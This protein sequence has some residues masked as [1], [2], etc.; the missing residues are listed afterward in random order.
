MSK[1]KIF[2]TITDEAP[3]LATHSFLPIVKAFTAPA[4]IEI[5]TSD[6]SL[7]GRTISNFAAALN[8]DQRIADDLVA[9]GKLATTPEANIIKL[10]NIS[11]S[12]PQLQEVIK[13]LQSLGYKLPN[14]PENPTTDDEKAIRAKYGKLLGSAVNPVL[15]EGNSD[16]R[17]PKAV[18]NYAKKNPHIMGAWSADSKTHVSSMD[19]GDFYGSETS[20]TLQEANTYK[21]EFTAVDGSVKTLKEAAPLLAG[22]IIDSAVLSV[23]ELKKF[24]ATQIADAKSSGVLFSLHLKATMMKVSDPIIFGAVVDVFFAPVF[25]KYAA[26]FSELKINTN[27]GFGD[28]LAKIQGRPEQAEVEAAIDA[29]YQMRPSV[30]MVNSDKGITNLNV[31]SD[32]IVDASMPAMIRTSGQMYNADGKGQDTK[33]VIPDRSYAGLYVATIDY[34]KK[35]GAFDPKTMGSVPNVGLMAQAAEEYGSHD[36]TFQITGEG[37]VKVIGSK[38]ETLLEQKVKTGDIFRMCQAKDAPIR[39]WVKLA[40]NRARLSDTPAVFWLDDQRAHDRELI[41]KVTV[42]L[43]DNDTNGLD[44]RILNP[45]DATL[46][47]LE[48]IK[49]G[50]DTI[51]VTGN[52]LRDYLTDLFPIL[53]L[54]TSAKM[55]SI[56]PLMNGGGLFETGAGGSAPKHVD[57]FLEEGHLRWDSLG[58][59]LALGA[60]LEH[61]GQTLNNEK[62]IVLAEALDNATEKF[63]ENDKSPTR[64]VGQIDTR[65][66]HFYI[67]LYWAQALA[68]QNKDAELK[69]TFSEIAKELTANESKI[70]SELIAAQGKKQDIG[71]YYKPN[72]NLTAAAMRPS[73]TLNEALAKL[74]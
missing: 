37:V 33:A 66:S 26:L 18:K 67:A 15:R 68:A 20:I 50:N 38:G 56:V 29:V 7:A 49:A 32:V 44:I 21:I 30:A 74:A 8:E 25:E 34:C 28:V 70:N 46:F 48:R 61:L 19:H 23:T 9:L 63:L 3:M 1:A 36:K 57:Q 65:G 59:F 45:I 54:G 13:E 73:K 14:Y 12:V 51:S 42:Y 16:R 40:V 27:N 22:E 53:E 31:P 60:S 43:K 5:E 6:I 72:D 69:T 55:L 17:A 52:V 47:T 35:N 71:G 58:E 10:P 62:A 39:D 11:A 41:K 64:K 2:Y 24:I 4:G